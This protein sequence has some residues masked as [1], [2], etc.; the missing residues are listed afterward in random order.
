MGYK[1]EIGK[2]LGQYYG[3]VYDGVYTTSDFTQNTD[4]TYTLKDDIPY[5]KGSVRSNVKVGDVKYKAI[6][7]EKDGSG[8]P[9]FSI[10]DRT[11]IGSAQP[12]FTG[13]MNNTFRYKGFDML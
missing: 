7:G 2:P 9:V 10:N 13:G 5:P 11:V 4:G 6:V 1:I 3:L 8:K 12:K